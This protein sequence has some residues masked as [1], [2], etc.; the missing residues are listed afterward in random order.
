MGSEAQSSARARL[1]CERKVL[2]LQQLQQLRGEY[3]AQGKVRVR[4]M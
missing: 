3:S 1:V 2:T 4:T